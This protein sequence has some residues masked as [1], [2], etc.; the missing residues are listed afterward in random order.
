MVIEYVGN[1]VIE[2]F[3]YLPMID[4]PIFPPLPQFLRVSKIFH[5]RQN[6]Q[7]LL[8][9]VDRNDRLR[10]AERAIAEHVEAP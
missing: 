8:W 2:N 5:L 6:F 3:C 10:G 4:G 9:H 7:W 1:L